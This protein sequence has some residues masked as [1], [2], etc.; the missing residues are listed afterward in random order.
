MGFEHVESAA[1][2]LGSSQT[3]E[4]L[5]RTFVTYSSDDAGADEAV[6]YTIDE[7]ADA[8]V[9]TVTIGM[10]AASEGASEPMPLGEGASGRAA[11]RKGPVVIADADDADDG[12]SDRHRGFLGRL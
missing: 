4:V 2:L 7:G 9:P 1:L 8:L 10:P 3:P 6:L 11:L 5:L 12:V